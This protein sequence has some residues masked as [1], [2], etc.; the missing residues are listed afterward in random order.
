MSEREPKYKTEEELNAFGDGIRSGIQGLTALL[1]DV[2][3]LFKCDSIDVDVYYGGGATFQ[4]KGVEISVAGSENQSPTIV[5]AW[6]KRAVEVK[7]VQRNKQGL[8][9]TTVSE[10]KYFDE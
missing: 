7:E 3:I 2:G 9:E 10:I 6:P 8:I 4:T 1:A 5:Q